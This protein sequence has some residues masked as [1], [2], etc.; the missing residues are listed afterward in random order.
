METGMFM[1]T[2]H[3]GLLV[4]D[5]EPLPIAFSECPESTVLN[6]IAQVQLFVAR[7]RNLTV[8]ERKQHD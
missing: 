6:P 7:P 8:S 4:E 1:K 5:L 3:W 2:G